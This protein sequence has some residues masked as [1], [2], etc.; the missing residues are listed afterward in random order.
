MTYTS[1]GFLGLVCRYSGEGLEG[2]SNTGESSARLPSSNRWITLL[3][4][5]S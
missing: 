3:G 4:F 5:W 1:E 2:C